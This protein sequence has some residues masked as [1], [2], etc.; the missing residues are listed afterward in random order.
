M[1]K[2]DTW[3]QRI[4]SICQKNITKMLGEYLGFIIEMGLKFIQ[5]AK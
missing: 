2:R 3:R 4:L 5:P 1:N